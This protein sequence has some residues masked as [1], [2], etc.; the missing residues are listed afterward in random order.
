MLTPLYI[1]L[2]QKLIDIFIVASVGWLRKIDG[3]SIDAVLSPGEKLD[4]E[5]SDESS[6][7]VWKTKASIPTADLKN[8]KI[9]VARDWKV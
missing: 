6:T 7:G 4:L 9:S 1:Y 5:W 8:T 3:G 2:I